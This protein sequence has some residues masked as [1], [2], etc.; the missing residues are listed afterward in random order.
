M[1]CFVNSGAR[2]HAGMCLLCID[3]LFSFR[4]RFFYAGWGV[5]EGV[6]FGLGLLV[7]VSLYFR[8]VLFCE[9]LNN[10]DRDMN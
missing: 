3:R 8:F 1:F 9:I 2:G 4:N 7:L 5:E 6:G 10:R